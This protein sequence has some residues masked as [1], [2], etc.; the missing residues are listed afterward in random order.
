MATFYALLVIIL[1][2]HLSGEPTASFVKLSVYH[3]RHFL[4]FKATLLSYQFHSLKAKFVIPPHH[5]PAQNC[6]CAGLALRSRPYT[7]CPRPSL[8]EPKSPAPR[9]MG[10]TGLVGAKG[11]SAEEKPS[12]KTQGQPLNFQDLYAFI[13]SF[14]I[15]Q[16][17]VISLF[18]TLEP[19]SSLEAVRH[20]HGLSY[21]L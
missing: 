8:A 15:S 13:C 12:F 16:R 19:P 14:L 5:H 10:T 18:L 1:F 2:L 17:K 4:A 7:L 9:P 20:L 11:C 6:P 3:R 21:Y